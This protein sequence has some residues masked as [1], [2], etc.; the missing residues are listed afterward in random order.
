MQSAILNNKKWD[1]PWFRHDDIKNGGK[2]ILVMG[3][4]PN[5]NWGNNI[6]A[7]PLSANKID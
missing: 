3:D 2:L 6:E 7:A 1:K 5:K 4:S